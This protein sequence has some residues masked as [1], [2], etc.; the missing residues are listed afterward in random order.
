MEIKSQLVSVHGHCCSWN[1]SLLI[2]K[3]LHLHFIRLLMQRVS[4]FI[5]IKAPQ[6]Y[7]VCVEFV[8]CGVRG[9][10]V[11]GGGLI[12]AELVWRMRAAGWAGQTGRAGQFS[13]G[14]LGRPS[15]PLWA[16][17]GSVWWSAGP[18]G[19]FLRT[20]NTDP[21]DYLLILTPHSHTKHKNIR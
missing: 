14:S 12:C 21:G 10:E 3:Q 5:N 1:S 8:L 9:S 16:V 17:A 11:T 13:C 2:T 15:G 6:G 20:H 18:A 19:C 7:V 4:S